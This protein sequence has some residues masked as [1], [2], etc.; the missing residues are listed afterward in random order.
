MA[1]IALHLW[2][3]SRFA[4]LGAAASLLA[5]CASTRL[6]AEWADQQ[7][8]QGG[9]ASLR[10][11]RVFVVCDA[12][13]AVIRQLCRERVAAEVVA[14]GATPI[15]AAEPSD[16]SKAQSR[17][18]SDHAE[19]ARVAGARA[20]L[21]QR[22]APYGSHP[23]PGLSLGIGGF[24]VGG[25]VGVGVG[26]SAPIGGGQIITGYSASARLIDVSS[27][28]LFWSAKASS[29]PSQNVP[30]QLTELTRTVFG[31]ADKLGVF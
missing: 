13:E 30:R 29:P 27:G 25:D 17:G 9:A 14:R 8:Q 20:V 2:S 11:A 31:S 3:R 21:V 12:R 4:A 10:G 18:D 6:D 26:V 1:G 28:R 15:M 7:G 5:A 24:N 19:A 23:S 22:L 16:A